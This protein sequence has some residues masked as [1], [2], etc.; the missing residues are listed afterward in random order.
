MNYLI[1]KILYFRFL[2]CIIL[3]NS[4]LINCSTI[5]ELVCKQY[6]CIIQGNDIN[7]DYDKSYS[8]NTANENVIINGTEIDISK[9]GYNVIESFGFIIKTE[10]FTGTEEEFYEYQEKNRTKLNPEERRNTLISY[11]RNF[12]IN[13]DS[14]N[15]G[16]YFKNANAEKQYN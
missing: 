11:Y 2:I 10:T 3:F 6:I 12:P 9:P 4:L 14:K 5:K 16:I 1:T 7:A 8:I 15:N 13:N